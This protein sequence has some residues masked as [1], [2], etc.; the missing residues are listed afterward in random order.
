MERKF[1]WPWSHEW[2]IWRDLKAT[3]VEVFADGDM[4]RGEPPI[5][6][7]IEIT[8]QRRCERCGKLQLRKVKA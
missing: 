5:R 8:Q 1:C 3:D 4:K 6:R 7:V 2:P